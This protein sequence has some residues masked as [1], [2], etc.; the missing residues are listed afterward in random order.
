MKVKYDSEWKRLVIAAES[1]R[2]ADILRDAIEATIADGVFKC[3]QLRNGEGDDASIF[4]PL[5]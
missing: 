5:T 2:D 1:N 4:V 3:I